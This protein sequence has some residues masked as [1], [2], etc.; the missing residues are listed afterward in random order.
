MFRC[1]VTFKSVP[2]T[3][4][5]I[6]SRTSSTAIMVID[7]DDDETTELQ[8]HFPGSISEEESTC[9]ISEAIERGGVGCGTLLYQIGSFLFCCME[10]AEILMMTIVGPVLR[11]EWD[12]SSLQ[13]STLQMSAAFAMMISSVLTSPFGDRYGRKP[14]A[15]VS[16][17]GVTTAAFLSCFTQNFWQFL[18]LRIVIGSLFGMGV[19]PALLL[20]GE[21]I[22]TRYR[23]CALSML[24]MTWG[25]GAAMGAG[26]AYLILDF[27]GWR[28]L[29]FAITATFSPCIVFLT[30]IKESP[31]HDYYQGHIDKAAMTI[32][33]IYKMNGKGEID[34]NLEYKE[35]HNFFDNK[36]GAR[37]VYNNLLQTD[38]I[39][40]LICLIMISISATTSYNLFVYSTPRLLNEGYCTGSVVTVE[41]SCDFQNDVL[42]DLGF[43]G[44]SEPLGVCI[45][46]YLIEVWGRKTAFISASLGATLLCIPLYICVNYSFLFWSILTVRLAMGVL[47]TPAILLTGEYMPTVIRSFMTSVISSF[48]RGIGSAAIF[49]VEYVY[50]KSPKLVVGLVQGSLL[51]SVVAL[52]A[53]KKDTVGKHLT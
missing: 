45:S 46:V 29:L 9:D 12:L 33:S 41:E 1:P 23:G 6:Q 36:L 43:L 49:S 32:K 3:L 14:V 26:E 40:N 53:L 42:F 38:N 50:T 11:C 30:L 15:L 47:G 31:R 17:I 52:F 18:A 51:L 44:L 2:N 28:V 24:A 21:T 25:I 8:Q 13:L 4:D 5:L 34:V 10:G 27:F 16:A 35:F 22:P 7:N 48:G 20:S 39:R 19:I 37:M